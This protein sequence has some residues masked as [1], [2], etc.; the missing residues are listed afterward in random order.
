MS[1]TEYNDAPDDAA[2]DAED[3]LDDDLDEDTVVPPD[4]DDSDISA[5]LVKEPV[6]ESVDDAVDSVDDPAAPPAPITPDSTTAANHARIGWER[7][8]NAAAEDFANEA[9]AAYIDAAV[10][11]G[12]VEIVTSESE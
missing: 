9:R 1:E 11:G 8:V 12:T 3:G 4:E 5:P 6:L 7:Q 2:L 10:N